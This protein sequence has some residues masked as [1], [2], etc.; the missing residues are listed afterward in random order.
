LLR[1]FA[2]KSVLAD[3][4]AVEFPHDE[5]VF[6][7]KIANS[8]VPALDLLEP[9]MLVNMPL[10]DFSLGIQDVLKPFA[11]AK[12]IP[13]PLRDNISTWD[14]VTWYWV[15]KILPLSCRPLRLAQ[16]ERRAKSFFGSPK[17]SQS[18]RS[19]EMTPLFM[20]I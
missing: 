18:L 14:R 13:Q 15:A 2:I 17:I 20:P 1:K 11:P 10:D 8:L 12:H 4:R 9:L 16:N 7:N 19:C 6:F 5:S 3:P